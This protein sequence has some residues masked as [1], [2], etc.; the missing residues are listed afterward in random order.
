MS[1]KQTVNNSATNRLH[2]VAAQELDFDTTTFTRA[3]P[4][5]FSTFIRVLAKNWQ[6]ST[7]ACQ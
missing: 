4:I 5:S 2:A 3:A 1:N 6:Q 7:V